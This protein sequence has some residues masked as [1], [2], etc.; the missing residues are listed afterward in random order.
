MSYQGWIHGLL[1]LFGS[2][3]LGASALKA[4]RLCGVLVFVREA[5]RQRVRSFLRGMVLLLAFFSLAY[6][7]LA[8]VQSFS[9]RHLNDHLVVLVLTSGAL[10]AWL[11]LSLSTQLL[12]EIER[13][14]RGVI[15]ICA[16]CKKVRREQGSSTN[17][18]DWQR[19]ESYISERSSVD[20]SH[21]YCPEC[22]ESELRALQASV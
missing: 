1:L 11:S 12:R 3:I 17:P 10:F 16:C 15:P 13:T 22:Y 4:W 18:D 5:R 9:V 14:L 2:A 21:G 19:I 7:A 6:A 20:F 8:V